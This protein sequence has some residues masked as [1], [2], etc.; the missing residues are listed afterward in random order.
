MSWTSRKAPGRQQERWEISPGRWELWLETTGAKQ[1][2]PNTSEVQ[3][4]ETLE[5]HGQGAGKAGGN[6][7]NTRAEGWKS[8]RKRLTGR[9]SVQ[10]QS[11]VRRAGGL[12]PKMI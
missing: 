12:S 7:G 9:P 1:S 11:G 6:L 8:W 3:A 10:E 5:T 4:G 2:H